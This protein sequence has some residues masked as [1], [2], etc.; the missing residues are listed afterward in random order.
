MFN[1]ALR[2]EGNVIAP[3]HVLI[4]ASSSRDIMLA[5]ESSFLHILDICML[6]GVT[7]NIWCRTCSYR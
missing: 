6:L 5:S 2:S 1:R 4:A 3:S 7:V